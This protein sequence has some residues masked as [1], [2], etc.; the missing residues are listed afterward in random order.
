MAKRKRTATQP[1][2]AG[3]FV[4]TRVEV[5]GREEIK[6]VERPA[7]EPEPWGADAELHIVGQ[8]IPRRDAMEK[9]TGRA[10]YTADMD[11]P[12]MLHTALVRARIAR[13]RVVRLDLAP[14]LAVPGVRDA[15]SE[16]D[17]GDIE[18]AGVPLFSAEVRYAG[19]PIAAV[20]ADTL[21]IARRAADS[22]IVE[23]ATAPHAVK[24][25]DVLAHEAPRVRD[26]G[27]V[28]SG[29]RRRT[30]R[31]DVKRGLDEAEEVIEREYRTQVALHTALEPHGAVAEW[32]GEHLTVWESTQGIFNTRSDIADA[33][34][35][36]LNHVR[37]VHEYMGGGFGAKNGASTNAYVAALLSRRTGRPVRCINDREGEQ[38]DS[39][40]RPATIQRVTLAARRDGRLTAMINDAVI[41]LG[42]DGW[43]GGPAKIFHELYSCPNVRTSETFVYTNTGAMNSFRAPGHVEG[44]FAL[45]CAM[46]TLA[47][48]L[49]IDPLELRMINYAERNEEKDREYS[50]KRLRECYEKLRDSRL[51]IRD[52]KTRSERAES[53]SESRISN[54]ESRCV[55]GVGIASQS[56]GTGGG[57]PAYALVRLNPDG[58]VDVLSGTQDLGTGS[59]TVFA[60]IAAEALGA[61]VE[62]V[63]VVI[64]DTERTPYTGNSW[65]SSTVSS[66]GPAVRMAAEDAKTQLLEAAAGLLD[67]DRSQLSVS[68]SVVRVRR[69]RRSITFAELGEELGDVMIIGRGSRGPNAEGLT[70]T[71]F[72]AQRAE[73]EVDVETG[74]VRVL[75]I[76]AVHDVGRVINPTL[77]ESQVEGGILQGLGYALFEERVLD[78]SIGVP[79]NPTMHD[80]KIPTL[81]DVPELDVTLLD[82]ADPAA[83]H[84]G[85]RGLGEPPIIPT[86]PA[87]ANAVANAIG[88]EITELPITP[89]RVLE[90][91]RLRD[92]SRDSRDT[93]SLSAR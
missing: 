30:A 70:L 41:P 14:A 19:Q 33:L 9:V 62:D 11:R 8:R 38:L 35:L 20:C 57:P 87:I 83:N 93:A 34:K 31:G 36:P 63:R 44:A 84:T 4:A 51:E 48:A 90:A 55:R 17:A 64:G 52:S 22:V 75:R 1:A 68:G 77:A 58:S 59:R 49:S 3:G 23:Y 5:E 24:A 25:E 86:A 47:A 29:G 42:I 80:Y 39:G 45:E 85:A 61:K 65:G 53:P 92:A 79:L 46:D 82:I 50:S 15:I 74:V 28:A 6:I 7:F 37:V 76:T 12:G 91:I 2:V 18:S 43:F 67:V 54:L 40:N 26:D 72:G 71:S 21:D 56:W 81:A 78:D 66:V 69:S 32:D 60:Q 89:W 27:N 73:V 16:P 88:A 13:G 10:C